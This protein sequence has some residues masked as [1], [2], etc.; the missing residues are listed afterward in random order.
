MR[1]QAL[2]VAVTLF[3][4]GLATS[5]Q[6]PTAGRGSGSA[7]RS[8]EVLSD[9]RVTFRI[10]APN[11][12]A[13]SVLCECLTLSEVAKLKQQR[14]QLG[15]RP[16]ND[17]EV[18]RLS[19]ELA[20]AQSRQG[21]RALSKDPSGVWSVTVGPI[22]PD[23][24]AYHFRIDDFE[25]LDPRNPVVKYNSRP[26]LIHSMLEVPG[27]VPMFYDIR[28][29]PHGKVDIRYYESKITKTTRRV[30]IYTP[31]NYERSSAKLPV[32]YLLHGAD[33]DETVWTNFGRANFI[34]DN[35]VSEKKMPPTIVVMPAGYAYPPTQSV[36]TDKQ[37]AD[38]ERDLLDA[39]IPFVQSNYRVAAD[40]D[41][42]A[43]AGLSM[44]GAQ[45]LA[46]GPRHVD[47]F[48]RLGVFSSAVSGNKPEESFKDVAANANSVNSQLKLFWISIGEEESGFA[49]AKH[50]S[51]FL[52]AA[53]VKNTFKTFHGGH[54]WSVWRR[55]L[56]EF[57]PLLWTST[58]SS[59]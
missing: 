29:V 18:L 10:A 39:L 17:P 12:S 20:R 24:W 52:K 13:V 34:I 11:A 44:G 32:L 41:H 25:I 37:R 45:T 26:T 21:E 15:S 55:S 59:E 36:P 58:S 53:G 28:S 3:V 8:P 33:G 9:R 48:S 47:V 40:R 19:R 38:F 30:F 57:A 46:I 49:A 27:P 6:G 7:I 1:I 31:A 43:L 2:A 23:I 54:T 22:E 51:D 35:L 50:T 16:E 4:L 14:A 5:A 56:N 42:R